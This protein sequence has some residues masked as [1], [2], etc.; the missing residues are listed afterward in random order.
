VSVFGC[1]N[2]KGLGEVGVPGSGP[3]RTTFGR[4][5][6]GHDA[7]ESNRGRGGHSSVEDAVFD[8]NS[9][10]TIEARQQR[11]LDCLW[12]SAPRVLAIAAN[13]LGIVVPAVFSHGWRSDMDEQWGFPGR[14]RGGAARVAAPLTLG[15]L[16]SA[17]VCR[18][19]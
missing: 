12:A 5:T 17:L 19:G 10:E 2:G 13:R 4:P 16:A 9:D 6:D 14:R 8:I 7:F 18:G 15:V 1:T 11:L 3:D